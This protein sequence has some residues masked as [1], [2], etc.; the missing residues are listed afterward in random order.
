MMKINGLFSCIILIYYKPT[1]ANIVCFIL[2]CTLY[3]YERC[4]P[5]ILLFYVRISWNNIFKDQFKG[6]IIHLQQIRIYHNIYTYLPFI[7]VYGLAWSGRIISL[8]VFCLEVRKT[9]GKG[10]TQTCLHAY[11]TRYRYMLQLDILAWGFK[12]DRIKNTL[13]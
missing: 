11:R 6:N 4:F 2:I 1:Q 8:S 12:V 9:L 10:N 3:I 7:N 5:D 13:S